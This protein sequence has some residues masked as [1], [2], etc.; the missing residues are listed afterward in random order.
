MANPTKPAILM[1]NFG[2]LS[3]QSYKIPKFINN[4]IDRLRLYGKGRNR[5]EKLREYWSIREMLLKY[6]KYN[7]KAIYHRRGK[8]TKTD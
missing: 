7:P 2:M 5:D 8:L 4:C 3:I 1:S 6:D